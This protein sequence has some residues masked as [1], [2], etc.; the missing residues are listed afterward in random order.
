MAQLNGVEEWGAR[1][2]ERKDSTLDK[3]ALILLLASH[4]KVLVAVT[5]C[6]IHV[7]NKHPISNSISP[8][9]RFLNSLL[10]AGFLPF[11]VTLGSSSLISLSL[12]NTHFTDVRLTQYFR[13]IS[14]I[15]CDNSSRRG[16]Q[17]KDSV[18]NLPPIK[19]FSTSR[20]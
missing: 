12:Y 10:S 15:E 16:E 1:A 14:L 17:V 9:F 5:S 19:V 20:Y 2:R 11:P 7:F 6:F 4:C 8:N 3:T 13:L 18:K